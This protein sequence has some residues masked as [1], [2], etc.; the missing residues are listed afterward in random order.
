MLHDLPDDNVVFDVLERSAASLKMNPLLLDSEGALRS[1]SSTQLALLI[2]GVAYARLLMSRGLAPHA[3]AGLSIGAYG[4]AVVAEVLSLEDALRLVMLRGKAMEERYTS[5]YGLA[6]I[7]GLDEK[8][9]QRLVDAIAFDQ[10]PLFLGNINGPKQIVVSGSDAALESMIMNS[11]SAGATKAELL[12]VPALSHCPL[13]QPIADMLRI[14]IEH[15]PRNPPTLP[16]ISNVRGRTLRTA[17]SI[18]T[19]LTDN[20]AHGVRWF[21]ATSVL[22]ELGCNLFL[23]MPPGHVL[24]DLTKQNQPDVRSMAVANYAIKSILRISKCD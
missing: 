22:E 19:D 17:E 14:E 9:V 6:A 13:L 5:G 10:T 21:D 18:L 2:C 3:V 16:Y 12:N 8:T 20:I 24:T 1:T 7:V 15:L 23:E 4:A 11:L